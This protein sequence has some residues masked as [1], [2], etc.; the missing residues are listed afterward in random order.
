MNVSHAFI[1]VVAVFDLG[2]QY[3]LGDLRGRSRHSSGGASRIFA[4]SR[5][6]S[7]VGV[8]KGIRAVVLVELTST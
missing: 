4:Q 8:S 2:R 5:R 3:V 1:V 7:L 6:S